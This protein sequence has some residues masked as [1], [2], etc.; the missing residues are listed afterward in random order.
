MGAVPVDPAAA[1]A[2]VAAAAG[3]AA[4][5]VRSLPDPAAPVPSLDWT[6][7]QTATHLVAAARAF[8]GYVT[9]QVIPDATIDL[10]ERNLDRIAQ[11]GERELPA[12]ADLLVAD[13][14]RYLEQTADLPADRPV[15]FYGGTTLALSSLHGILLGEYLVHGLD[16]ARS[17]G[18]PWP[19]D[20]AQARLVIAAATALLPRY[21][22]PVAARGVTAG[23]QVRG[24]RFVLRVADGEATV[25]PGAAGPVDCHI[26]AD[27]VAFLEVAYGRRS[28]W[29]P[30]LRGQMTAWGRR[31][32]R[33]FG[34]KRLLL[35]P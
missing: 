13:T 22:D 19:I 23:Y 30:V 34:F 11:V 4:E 6:V 26:S 21:L 5:L 12:L 7:A 25:E 28:Q 8:L 24:P 18:R 17:A 15:P 32:W 27:P 14:R 29:R 9:G 31:P 35:N 33:A 1:R 10:G 16:L 3:Q 2:G 20:P